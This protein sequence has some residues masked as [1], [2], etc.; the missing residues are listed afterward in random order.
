MYKIIRGYIILWT[1]S[2]PFYSSEDGCS[3]DWEEFYMLLSS[4]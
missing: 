2:A 3:E 1:V 4:Q